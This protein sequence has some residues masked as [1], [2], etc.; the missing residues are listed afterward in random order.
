M[1]ALG[2]WRRNFWTH[3]GSPAMVSCRGTREIVIGDTAWAPGSQIAW[4]TAECL[5]RPARH[6]LG[7]QALRGRKSFSSAEG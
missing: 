2:Q 5:W 7:Q 3:S 6:L 4:T 1:G